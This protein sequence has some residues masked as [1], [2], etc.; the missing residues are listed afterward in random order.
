MRFLERRPLPP[1][2]AEASAGDPLPLAGEGKKKVYFVP[3]IRSP[4]SPKPGTM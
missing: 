4:A 1:A 2:F 3:Y